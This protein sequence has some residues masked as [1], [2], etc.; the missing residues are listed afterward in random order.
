MF[1]GVVEFLFYVVIFVSRCYDPVFIYFMFLMLMIFC[2]CCYT[3]LFLVSNSKPILSCFLVLDRQPLSIITLLPVV[4]HSG[5]AITLF[6]KTALQVFLAFVKFQC[7]V[8]KTIFVSI[9][10]VFS[11]SSV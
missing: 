4:L 5:L 1:D 2:C 10:R 8:F 6:L 9:Y 3:V 7:N 11:R